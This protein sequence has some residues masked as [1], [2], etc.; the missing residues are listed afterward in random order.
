M[1]STVKLVESILKIISHKLVILIK[2]PV[3]ADHMAKQLLS[4]KMTSVA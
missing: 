4:V 3:Y 1:K 2:L